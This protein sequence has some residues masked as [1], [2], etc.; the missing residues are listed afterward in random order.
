MIKVHVYEVSR[1]YII[2]FV[3]YTYF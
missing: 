1:I 2:L 3:Y